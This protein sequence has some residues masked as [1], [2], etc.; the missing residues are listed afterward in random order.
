MRLFGPRRPVTADTPLEGAP[1]MRPRRVSELSA[2]EIR[3]SIDR[4]LRIF[5]AWRAAGGRRELELQVVVQAWSA[6]LHYA[7][8]RKERNR[9]M[10][11]SSKRWGTGAWP[12]QLPSGHVAI[13][14]L[15]YAAGRV[16]PALA[17]AK[18]VYTPAFLDGRAE[19]RAAVELL[20]MQAVRR[21]LHMTDDED[22]LVLAPPVLEECQQ[23]RVQHRSLL[24]CGV[25]SWHLPPPDGLWRYVS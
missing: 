1:E 7:L 22:T 10:T 11:R 12:E 3:E 6:G 18:I 20:A 24:D 9:L 23:T 17:A 14:V 16:C 13:L 8:W 25:S 5:E 2:S 19:T 4:A 15:P 21:W